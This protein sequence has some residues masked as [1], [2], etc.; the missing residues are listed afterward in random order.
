[1][2]DPRITRSDFQR[3]GITLSFPDNLLS[4]TCYL[5]IIS[6]QK[7]YYHAWKDPIW[8]VA[9]D[10]EINSLH[11]NTTW[12]L[13]SL[14]PRRELIQCKWVFQTNIDAYGSTY[15]YKASLV[16]KF[17]SRVQRVDYHET[18]APIAKMDSIR[19]VLAI[20]ASKHWEVHHMDIK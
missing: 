4:K 7:S 9:M 14:P 6:D 17:F 10:E 1:M 8:K 16:A 19:L 11:K 3:A 2:N 12:E 20:S 13:V 15:K 5:M 18:F